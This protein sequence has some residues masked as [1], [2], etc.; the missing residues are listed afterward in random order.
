MT[1]PDRDT[2]LAVG[3]T[4]VMAGVF[5]RGWAANARRDQARRKEHRIDVRKSTVAGLNDEFDRPPGWF[6]RNLDRIAN[7]T[8]V[9]GIV[10]S[11]LAFSR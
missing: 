1:L 10:L 6:E 4:L 11:A 2:L 5:L 8:L 9:T 3:V 7:L